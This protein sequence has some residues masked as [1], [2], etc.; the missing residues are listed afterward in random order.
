M[1]QFLYIHF[2]FCSFAK[3][4]DEFSLLFY[5]AVLGLCCFAGFSLVVESGGYSS[6]AVCGLLI[7][8]ASLVVEQGF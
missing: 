5:M 8:V 2:V 1:Q 6:L 7:A 4:I 3:F